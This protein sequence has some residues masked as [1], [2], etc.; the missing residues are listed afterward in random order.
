MVYLKPP[1]FTRH[2]VNPVVSRLR[3]GG[4]EELTVTGRRTG[5]PR[6]VPVIPVQVGTHRYLVAP[7]GESGW[8][9]NTA[10]PVRASSTD[11][12]SR[13]TSSRTRS[14]STSGPRSSTDTAG[15]LVAASND[16]SGHYLTRVTIPS[17][18]SRADSDL[19]PDDRRARVVL[20]SAGRAHPGVVSRAQSDEPRRVLRR[21]ERGPAAAL[22]RPAPESAA[23]APS[24]KPKLYQPPLLWIS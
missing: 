16:A 18:R 21:D 5:Q 6:R 3:T 2:V 22:D 14:L 4:V 24:M 7:F 15:S 1:G 17:S 19:R 11:T 20:R 9:Q 12:G 10:R 13:S 23:D 8:V